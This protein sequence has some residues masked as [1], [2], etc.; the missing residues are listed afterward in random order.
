MNKNKNSVKTKNNINVQN[1]LTKNFTSEKKLKNY[2]NFSEQ[3]FNLQKKINHLKIK[4]VQKN[5]SIP[6]FLFGKNIFKNNSNKSNKSQSKERYNQNNKN[7]PFLK[8]L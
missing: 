5:K 7:K 1:K 6:R 2:F 3:Y 4:T 8:F